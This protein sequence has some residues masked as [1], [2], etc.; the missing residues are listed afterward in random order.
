MSRITILLVSDIHGRIDNIDGLHKWLTER[1]RIETIDFI[2]ASGDLV[3]IDHEVDDEIVKERLRLMFKM[4]YEY[5]VSEYVCGNHDPSEAF[6]MYAYDEL[7]KQRSA[8]S[9]L[10]K[11]FH[12]KVIDIAPGLSMVGF[13]GST[14]AALR[15]EP[16]K[17]VWP[18]YPLD[19]ESLLSKQ[20]PILFSKVPKQNDIMLVTHVGPVDVSTTDVNKYPNDLKERISGGSAAISRHIANESP[21]KTPDDVDV[22]TLTVNVHGHTHFPFGI[23]HIGR[24]V[25]VNPGPLRDGRFAILT[26]ER[27][28]QDELIHKD[29]S[30]K[31][32]TEALQRKQ[33]WIVSGV[34]FYLI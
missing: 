29:T 15:N 3:T 8:G 10:V 17:V 21:R 1:Q 26:L 33:V 4:C 31:R 20:L 28:S 22:L 19:T 25:I 13:G 27:H 34:E 11:N 32:L 12:N 6:Y 14:E 18:A 23:S 5:R 30:R 9:D 24:T 2:I 7:G 16:S